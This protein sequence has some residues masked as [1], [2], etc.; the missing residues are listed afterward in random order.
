MYKRVEQLRSGI[1]V[2]AMISGPRLAHLERLV[3]DAVKA[4]ARVL[5]GGNSYKHPDRPGAHHFQPTL[6]CDVTEDMAI[7]REE[8]FAPI[9]LA[10]RAKVS[11][12]TSSDRRMLN[13]VI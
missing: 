12:R 6:I 2:G 7:A 1:D 5:A 3:A 4:G 9:M 10:M 11:F 8:C 13:F